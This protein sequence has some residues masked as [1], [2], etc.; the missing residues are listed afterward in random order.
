MSRGVSHYERTQIASMLH[1]PGAAVREGVAV[2][3]CAEGA[4]AERLYVRAVGPALRA[5]GLNRVDVVRVFNSDS[6]LIDVS[7]WLAEAELVVA[8]L[9][10]MNADLMYVLGLAHGVGRCPLMLVERQHELPFNL[11]GLRHVQYTRN[12]MGLIELRE[13]LT[14]AVR[15]FL[16]AARA[17]DGGSSEARAP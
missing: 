6:A 12:P 13:D 4:A 16:A 11:A 1:P 2:F 5:N 7:R 17:S 14:R 3:L 9:S 15:V 10:A 8:E